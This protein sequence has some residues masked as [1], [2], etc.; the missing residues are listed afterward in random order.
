[1]PPFEKKNI[2][3]TGGAGFI[4]SHLIE[5]LLKED[6][7]VI[8]M[9]TFIT[10]SERNIDHLLRFPN[11]EFL[12]HDVTEPIVLENLPELDRFK[13]KFQGLQEI[14]HL[15][16]PTSVKDFEKH[17][18][19]TLYSNSVG[20][21]NILELAKKYQ[22]KFLLGSS[23]VIYGSR[24]ETEYIFD[25]NH[26]GALDHLTPRGAYDE[27]KRYAESAARTYELS[28][29]V[30]V[31]IARIFR[32]YG[33]RMKLDDAQLIP[34]FIINAL[35]GKDLSIYGDETFRTALLYV[36]DVVSGL[37]KLMAA[38][39]DIGP[40]NLGSDQ[41]LR[42]VDVAKKII[43][44]TASSSKIVFQPKL[45]FM[46]ELGLPNISKAR[47]AL[48]WLPLVRLEDGLLKTITYAKA[49]RYLMNGL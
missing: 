33:P 45:L 12:R 19:K 38:P 7:N 8:C 10:S 27:G 40:I 28:Y 14:Y 20:T 46:T 39:K 29:G 44:M 15:A 1:M 37:I 4:G 30:E 34:D 13:L 22:A 11:F 3:V 41:D 18:V 35:E 9:D 6:V 21:L 31:K 49:N 24:T 16:C 2:L 25:E 36:D 43:E 48:G 42:I 26:R 5:R 17:V 47:D 23:S 32:T